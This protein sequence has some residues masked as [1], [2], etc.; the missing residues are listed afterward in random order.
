MAGRTHRA[1]ARV[2]PVTAILIALLV[3]IIGGYFSAS[4]L[5]TEEAEAE[6]STSDD[7]SDSS[8]S[9]DSSDSDATQDSEDSEDSDV[10]EGK[11]SAAS[12]NGKDG[13]SSETEELTEGGSSGSNGSSGSSGAASEG[14]RTSGLTQDLNLTS[15]KIESLDL[16]AM[17]EEYVIFTFEDTVN[18]IEDES[19]FSVQGPTTQG[20]QTSVSARLVRDENNQVLVG[21]EDGTD[22]DQYRIASVDTDV[23]RDESDEGNAP[24]TVALDG[25]DSPDSGSPTGPNLVSV[26]VNT[27]LDRV[28]Y[29]YDRELDDDASPSPSDY[30]Y[31]TLSGRTEDGAKLVDVDDEHVSVDFDSSVE[32]AVRFYAKAGA[33]DDELGNPSLPGSVGG[34]TTAPELES[35]DRVGDRTQYEFSFSEDVTN[36]DPEAFLIYSDSG[37]AFSA[38]GWTRVDA[39]T[40]RLSFPDTR[41]FGSQIQ[42]GAVDEGAVED[43]GISNVTNTLSALPISGGDSSGGAGMTD[44]PDLVGTVIDAETGQVTFE[45]DEELDDELEPDPSDFLALTE[46]GDLVESRYFVEIGNDDDTVV[47]T[48]DSNIVEASDG[49]IVEPGA[50]SDYQGNPNPG[51]LQ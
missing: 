42:T 35:V 7:S 16:D 2:V 32:D 27:T 21:F 38:D 40:V 12:K 34:N 46:E 8:D 10:R 18:S 36:V 4:V 45:W 49:F 11:D 37:E 13:A 25:A 47:M 19:G 39:E 6:S 3:A 43:N 14:T 24:V 50:V 17:D 51:G 48:F 22:L 5:P 1:S 9:K 44:G 28:E 23:V 29:T 30:G 20:E 15:A 41:D 33:T 26:K 31:R